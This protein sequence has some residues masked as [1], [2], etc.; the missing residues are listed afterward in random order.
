MTLLCPEV[1]KGGPIYEMGCE[2]SNCWHFRCGS[3]TAIALYHLIFIDNHFTSCE[4]FNGV[5]GSGY[6]N[7]IVEVKPNPQ[8]RY[9]M[10]YIY[11]K[12]ADCIEQS[13]VQISGN[14]KG[15]YSE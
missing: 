1:V 7:H 6:M 13:L 12:V 14:V 3:V 2:L 15:T 5:G 10:L 11:R 9:R 8:W 4:P